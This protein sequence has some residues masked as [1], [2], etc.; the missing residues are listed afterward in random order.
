MNTERLERIENL[1]LKANSSVKSVSSESSVIQ[2]NR[3][4]IVSRSPG[5]LEGESRWK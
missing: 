5:L 4:E 2:T 3:Q 1:S